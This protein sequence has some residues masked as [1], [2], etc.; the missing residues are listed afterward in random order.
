MSANGEQ[1]TPLHWSTMLAH[2]AWVIGRSVENYRLGYPADDAIE[3]AL[4]VSNVVMPI[5]IAAR[6]AWRMMTMPVTD[7]SVHQIWL[8]ALRTLGQIDRKVVDA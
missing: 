7:P 1:I 4:K 6:V 3:S 8:D 5:E 2:L